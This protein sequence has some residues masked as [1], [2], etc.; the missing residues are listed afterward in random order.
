MTLLKA[1][2]EYARLHKDAMEKLRRYELA[3]QR[4]QGN[5]ELSVEEHGAIAAAF[6]RGDRAEALELLRRHW[7]R[8]KDEL[9]AVL[10]EE[11]R[12]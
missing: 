7:H 2:P 10:P 9:L 4:G 11:D 8:G 1:D 3:Y 5:M 12:S 6:E